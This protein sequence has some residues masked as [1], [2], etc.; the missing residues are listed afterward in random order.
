[1]KNSPT[2][3][4]HVLR[5]LNAALVMA[6]PAGA[7]DLLPSIPK[8]TIAIQLKTVV[9]GLAA[10][11]YAISPPPA[12]GGG[13]VDARLF[14]LEQKG[15]ILIL[16]GG[17]LLATPA[18]DMQSL[19]SPPMVITSAN[20][21]RGLLGLAFHPRFND[22]AHA[23]YR[24]L[25]TYNSQPLG[26]GVTYAAPAGASQGYKN[27]INEWKIDPADPNRI[28]PASRR[29]IISFGKN[30]NNHNG[31]TIA[32]GPDGYLYLGLGDGGNANDVGASHI[33]PGG[34]AQNLTTPLG[35]MLRLDPLNPT[36]NPA[37]ADP[38]SSNSQYRIPLTNPFQGAGQVREIHSYG[39]RNPYRFAFDRL[40][41]ELIAAD[42]GQNNVEEIDRVVL[43]GNFGW[44]VKEGDFLFNRATGPGGTI[45]SVGMR[46]VG[47]PA[48]LIDPISGNLGTLE[49]DHEDGISITGGFVYR[50]TALPE[51]A[52]KYVFGDLALHNSPARADGRLFYAD[53]TTG[54]IAEFLLPQFA[55]GILPDGLTV[56][57]F[58]EDHAGEL[59][60]LVTNTPSSGT[61]GVVYAI[62]RAPVVWSGPPVSFAKAV[63]ADWTLPQNQDR[64]TTNVWL[65]R[66]TIKGIFNIKT[67]TAYANLA[68]PADTEWAY[69]TTANYAALT[70]KNWEAWTGGAGG[71]PPSTVGKDAVVHLISENIYLDLKFTIWGATGGQMA[72]TRSS[73]VPSAQEAWR[74][75]Y[76][77][78]TTNTGNAADT[79]DFDS[80]GLVN[81]IEYAFGLDPT[82]GSPQALPIPQISGGNLAVTFTQPASVAN[83]VYQA[84]WSPSM[85]AGSWAFLTDTGTG[86]THTF[87]VPMAGN[88]KAFL[89][90]VVTVL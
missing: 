69:G 11:D 1:M 45:G 2:A 33:E 53:L 88:N 59:Y 71:G 35:K 28:D 3:R 44:A 77:N 64:L 8:G 67:E 34:N 52:G 13:A 14:I 18:L 84:Q 30:A 55:G 41:G 89:R 79:F 38:I 43:G 72:Y 70:Y 85:A 61:G 46:S 76:F 48:G 15:L 9:T 12:P 63:S 62:Q 73:P 47:T 31:G 4:S 78:V 87:T 75:Q 37:S 21:E 54:R 24:T 5:F 27:A 60:A 16:Q 17:S 57:G 58:G 10:P 74:K 49:Y 7:V 81:L 26:T 32:F 66:A 51:L 6:L 42:V 19:V 65:T 20:D 90:Y 68:S 82:T 23:G 39:F 29:E 83:L 80:D 56:H 36:L 25:Y 40:N 50:G 86:S 22:A